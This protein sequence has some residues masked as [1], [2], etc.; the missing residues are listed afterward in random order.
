MDLSEPGDAAQATLH[1]GVASLTAT[2]EHA[3]LTLYAEQVRRAP[4][5]ARGTARPATTTPQTKDGPSRPCP[6]SARA[7]KDAR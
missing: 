3:P 5:E 1:S 7:R 2:D 4:E 6:R